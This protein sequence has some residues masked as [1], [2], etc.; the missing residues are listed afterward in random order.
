MRARAAGVRSARLW[1]PTGWRG[2][3]ANLTVWD[4]TF[5]PL[6]VARVLEQEGAKA[7]VLLGAD[8]IFCDGALLDQHLERCLAG[9]A[10]DAGDVGD[11]QSTWARGCA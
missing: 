7:A 4:E 9:H 10:G 8:W 5:A 11:F 3:I 1:T 6:A 2:G